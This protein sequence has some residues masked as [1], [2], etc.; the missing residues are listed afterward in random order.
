MGLTK[1]IYNSRWY[2]VPRIDV[3]GISRSVMFVIVHQR[4]Y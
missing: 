1:H 3:E 2:S 4:R